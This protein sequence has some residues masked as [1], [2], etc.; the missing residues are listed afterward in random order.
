MVGTLLE[1]HAPLDVARDAILAAAQGFM[2]ISPTELRQRPPS[3]LYRLL[4]RVSKRSVMLT[5]AGS[6]TKAL[7]VTRQPSGLLRWILGTEWTLEQVEFE[8]QIHQCQTALEAAGFAVKQS[9]VVLGYEPVFSEPA[10]KTPA[11]LGQAL[12]VQR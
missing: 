5:E 2:M 6:T 7:F 8:R 3:L 9:V 4:F 12:D 1:I 10:P 11:A